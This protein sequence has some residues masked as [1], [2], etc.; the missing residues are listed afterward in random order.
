MKTHAGYSNVPATFNFFDPEQFKA[1]QRVCK[2]FAYSELVPTIYRVKGIK[3]IP[4]NATP[5]Q[6]A[7]IQANNATAEA[8]AMANCLIA[9]ETSM[10]I[11]VSVLAVMQNMTVIHGR[12]SWSS[13]FLIGT[14]NSCGRY[15]TLKYRITTP[16]N[17]GMVE[18]TEYEWDNRQNRNVAV[19]RTFDGRNI[20]EMVCVAYTTEKGSDEILESPP[21]SLTMAIQEGWYT[22]SG[23]KWPTMPQLMLKYRAASMW[24]NTNAPELSMGMKTVEEIMDIEDV[25]FTEVYDTNTQTMPKKPEWPGAASES[26]PMSEEPLTQEAKPE[27]EPTPAPTPEPVETPRPETPPTAKPEWPGNTTQAPQPRRGP[28]F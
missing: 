18:Y 6:A 23:S 27:P 19:Q 22:K 17:I 9:I 3:Q 7:N 26:A 2:M 4:A 5:E 21:V 28:G 16:G 1:M 14:I 13:K 25:E 8:Q 11:G 15:N 10:R 20:P 12:P 24:V